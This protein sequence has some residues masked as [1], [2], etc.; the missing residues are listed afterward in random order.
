VQR[1]V[2]VDPL[3]YPFRASRMTRV[4]LWPVVGPFVFKQLF[5]RRAFRAYFRDEV[6]A[7]GHPLDVGRLDALYDKF[8]APAARESAYATL[9]TLQDTRAI[10]ARIGRVRAPTL[11]VWGRHDRVLDPGHAPR[12]VRDLPKAKLRMLECAHAPAEERPDEL[13]AAVTSF[14]AGDR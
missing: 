8:N 3:V 13:V 5:G 11:V 14:L 4:P 6:Y 2:L 12:L 1:L 9:R 7:P 10:T